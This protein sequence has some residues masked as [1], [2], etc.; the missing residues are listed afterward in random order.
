MTQTPA[1]PDM[2]HAPR[3]PL[4]V[5]NRWWFF[6]AVFLSMLLHAVI[7]YA[8]H[9]RNLLRFNTQA[10]APIEQTYQ[11]RRAQPQLGVQPKRHGEGPAA[12][13][14]SVDEVDLSEVSQVLLIDD[15][16]LGREAGERPPAAVD[17][18]TEERAD[19]PGQA[20]Q[21]VMPDAAL[22]ERVVEELVGGL[23]LQVDYV[24]VDA[25]GFGDG[26]G[27]MTDGADGGF[28][29]SDGTG[30]QADKQTAAMLK[31]AGVRPTTLPP[32][33]DMPPPPITRP[34]PTERVRQTNRTLA[35]PIDFTEMALEAV[36][37]LKLPKLLDSDFEYQLEVFKPKKRGL[38]GGD[39]PPGAY[40]KV[41]VAGR[42]SLRKLKAMQK[43]IIL[44]VDTSGSVSSKWVE[45]TIRGLQD[46]LSSLNKGDRFNIVFF[47]DETFLFS[48]DPFVDATRRN[49]T[50]AEHFLSQAKSGGFTDVNQAMHRFLLRDVAE[51]RVYE[52]V[53]ISDGRSTRGVTETRALINLI[54]KDN[55]RAASIYCIGIGDKQERD[56]LQF[57]AYQ[58]KGYCVFAEQSKRA[59]PV[60][61]KLISDLR[62]PL[63][64]DVQL[65]VAGMAAGDVVPVNIPNIHQGGRFSIFG[66][67]TE[68][69]KFTVR[70][71]G[72]NHGK[73]VAFTFTR[74]LSQA[75]PGQSR[76]MQDWALWR[77]H[78][79]ASERIRGGDEDGR[80]LEQ[81]ERLAT[82]YKLPMVK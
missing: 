68:L 23:F 51:D 56:V 26:D 6:T 22:Q 59:A 60:I 77:L 29:S 73:D 72:K 4:V 25:A 11:V 10:A 48:D 21:V 79:L 52:L 9:D 8:V 81:M 37:S 3:Q 35:E 74:D 32:P 55:D 65:T 64:T 70:I 31:A 67:F 41:D 14:A 78:H 46:S 7:A 75:R 80:I 54:T 53:L 76:M 12:D 66:R 17:R 34:T 28:D 33:G 27:G 57:L 30:T 69:N 18:P 5:D 40:F 61:R 44:L 2:K 38:F 13:T 82:R 63:I 15:L 36:T 1:P 45:Q 20:P 39:E 58:N 42:K 50:E 19:D 24:E 43:D 62:Y 49:R 16:R 47:K 71:S